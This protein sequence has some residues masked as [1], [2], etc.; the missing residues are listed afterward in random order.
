MAGLIPVAAIVLSCI[1]I[2]KGWITSYLANAFLL[3]LSGLSLLS[4]IHQIY[5]WRE[6][7]ACESANEDFAKKRQENHMFFF[8]FFYTVAYQPLSGG[9]SSSSSEESRLGVQLT[10]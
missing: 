4:F 1:I 2:S 9:E 3:V 8:L 7:K 5:L 10:M 6:T